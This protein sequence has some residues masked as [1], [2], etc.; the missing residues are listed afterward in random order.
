MLTCSLCEQPD[1]SVIP[2]LV[3][4]GYCEVC[5]VGTGGGDAP[6]WLRLLQPSVI[7]SPLN[8]RRN[9]A[10]YVEGSILRKISKD[11]QH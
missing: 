3:G 5:F 4:P 11:S 7:L 10:R 8:C 2:E 9:C 1:C 6:F